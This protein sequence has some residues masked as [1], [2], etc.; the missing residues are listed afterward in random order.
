M[1]ERRVVVTGLGAVTPIGN[2]VK[3]F[4]KSCIEGKGGVGPITGFDASPFDSRIAGEI[5]NFDPSPCITPKE[6][7]HMDRFVQLAVVSA[8]EALADSGMDLSKENRDRVGVLIGSGIGGL[9]VIEEQHNV[10]LQKGAGR[11]SPFL[12][13]MLIVN[14]APGQ[15]AIQL[16]LRGPNSCVATACASG[17]HAVGDAFRVIQRGEADVMFAGGTESCVTRLGVGGFCAMH[18]LSTRNDDPAHASRPFDLE[19]D[20]FVMAEGSGIVVLEELEHARARGARIYAEMVG[21]GMTGDG[22][23]MTAPVPD[24]NGAIRCM[25]AALNDAGLNLDDIGYINAH[26]TSTK[27]N[28]KIET[29]AVKTLFGANAKKIPVS[30]TKSMTGHLLGAA[31]GVELIVCALSIRDNVL[32]PTINYEHPD[33]ECDLDYVPNKS[34]EKKLDVAMSNSLGFGGHNATLIVKRFNG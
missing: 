29:L 25:R 8:K 19:R 28:D 4:W 26:G 34:R 2:D 11:L 12:I 22:Y 1:N 32:A 16:G 9:K 33:P 23:H 18:A 30:S 3:D 31:G 14:M 17:G 6:L 5:K 27:L 20:G 7:R 15:V 13:P 10:L 21:Y 24:G